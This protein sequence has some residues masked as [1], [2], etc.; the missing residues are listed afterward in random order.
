[1]TA[2][3]LFFPLILWNVKT[4]QQNPVFF[5]IDGVRYLVA[6]FLIILELNWIF[7]LSNVDTMAIKQGYQEFKMCIGLSFLFLILA[8]LYYMFFFNWTLLHM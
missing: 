7:L 8:A 2:C 5:Y 3:P 6:T 1:M 4:F